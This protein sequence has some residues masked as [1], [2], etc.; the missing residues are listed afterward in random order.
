[1]G[2]D[3]TARSS[4]TTSSEVVRAVLANGRTTGIGSLPHRDARVAARFALDAMGLPAIPT[5]PKRSPAEGMIAQAVVGID[6]IA[7]GQYGS[8]AVDA[9]RIDPAR[10]VATDLQHDAF[11][12]FRAFLAEAATARAS[13]S[14][15]L[16]AVKW[17]LV[18]PVTL[19]T[20]LLRAGVP[21]RI[22]FD[23]AAQA[24][25]A[26]VQALLGAVDR[27]LPGCAQVVFLDEPSMGEVNEPGFPLAPDTAIDL[28]SGALAAIEH[29]AV[30]GVH[31]CGDADWA[32]LI[33][34]GPRVLGV[35]AH[36]RVEASAGYL[37]DFLGRG[38]VIAWGVVP[39]DGPIP[40]SAE[41]PWRRLTDLWCRLVQRGC[42]QVQLRQQCVVSPECG[43]GMHSAPVAERV[44]RLVAEVGRRVHDQATATRFVLGA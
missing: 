16:D 26:H 38:G 1:V 27:A 42:D 20:A 4:S 25:R 15:A 17:Q 5:L 33:S 8:I 34:A 28:V 22:A 23:V 7:I 10:P 39:T 13:G 3:A 36:A 9:R 21:E 40:L 32:A 43:L 29:R 14:N 19:G 18:G 37:H 2:A 24:V 35:P 6:G 30:A 41:R 44:H 12:G 11:A 31:C